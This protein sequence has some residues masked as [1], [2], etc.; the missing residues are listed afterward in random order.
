VGEILD[1]EIQE[2]TVSQCDV[3]KSMGTDGIKFTKVSRN[4][5]RLEERGIESLM[6]AQSSIPI[7]LSGWMILAFP[8]P[9]PH[10]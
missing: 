6:Q 10:R 4:P 5:C 8:S 2:W 3:G 9:M 1:T 7:R